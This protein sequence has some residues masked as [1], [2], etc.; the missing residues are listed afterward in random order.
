MK[1][2]DFEKK[3]NVVRFYLGV[4]DLTGYYGDDWDDSPYNLNAGAVYEE[5]ISGY[6]DVAFPFDSFVMEPCDDWHYA[7][8]LWRKDDMRDRRVPCIIVVPKPDERYSYVDERSFSTYVGDDNVTKFYFNDKDFESKI[9]LANGV[10]LKKANLTYNEE[11]R[12][13]FDKEGKEFYIY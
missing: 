3:G 6:V 13:L 4:D 11:K 12:T 8:S 7:N 10:I 9:I 5:Y 1:I 2:I